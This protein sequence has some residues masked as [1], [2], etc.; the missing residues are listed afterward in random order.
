[1]C[2]TQFCNLLW[3]Q[4]IP[5]SSSNASPAEHNWPRYKYVVQVVIGEQRGEAVRQALCLHSESCW[6]I[7]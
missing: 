4:L 6:V 2:E 7:T 3:V 5:N 1:M